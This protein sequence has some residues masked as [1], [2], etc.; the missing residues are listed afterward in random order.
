[1]R[2][3]VV[4]A[5]IAQGSQVTLVDRGGVAFA[6][7]PRLPRGVVRLQVEDAGPDDAATRAALQVHGDLPAPLRARVATVTASSPASVVLVLADG[8][9]VVWGARGDTET[10]AAAALALLPKPGTIVDVS[11]PGVAVRR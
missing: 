5:G 4:A 8:E 7:E 6:T 2:E 1:M 9:Q 3:R 10:K 11:A